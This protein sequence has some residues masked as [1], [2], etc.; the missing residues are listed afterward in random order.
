MAGRFRAAAEGFKKLYSELSATAAGGGKLT[1]ADRVLWFYSL[2]GL[3][4]FFRLGELQMTEDDERFLKLIVR[5]KLQSSG[6]LRLH[7]VNAAFA[8][9]RAAYDQGRRE[10][11][12]HYYRD[13][14]LAA[15]GITGK[16]DLATPELLQ[17][18]SLS[19][20]LEHHHLHNHSGSAVRPSSCI[21]NTAGPSQHSGRDSCEWGRMLSVRALQPGQVRTVCG[22]SQD[23]PV[24]TR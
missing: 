19:R 18:L 20:T 2:A 21:S 13:C 11:A 16:S 8:L 6:A 24:D 9:G 4:S 5:E 3:S 1:E 12:V 17:V 23:G 7:A 15:E 14:I 10:V 22:G